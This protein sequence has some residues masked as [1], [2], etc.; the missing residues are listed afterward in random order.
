MLVNIICRD[1]LGHVYTLSLAP[2]KLVAELI[3][4]LTSKYRL[5][6]NTKAIFNSTCLNNFPEKT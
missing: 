4:S 3:Q 5:S 1:T 2:N 6:A